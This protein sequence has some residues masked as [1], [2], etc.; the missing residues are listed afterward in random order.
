[1]ILFLTKRKSG[2]LTWIF[3]ENEGIPVK[4]R[5]LSKSST[6]SSKWKLDYC[7]ATFFLR[8]LSDVLYTN[9]TL[10][11]VTA[12]LHRCLL[13]QMEKIC[14]ENDNIDARW[15]IQFQPRYYII[16]RFFDIFAYKSIGFNVY[17]LFLVLTSCSSVR[18][19]AIR[20]TSTNS[21]PTVLCWMKFILLHRFV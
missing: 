8:P 5:L 6:V 3:L 12:P 21:T 20:T 2:L 10:H 19:S 9:W 1:M 18:T 15:I 14:F 17:L 16:L 7:R 13:L 4:M 11:L